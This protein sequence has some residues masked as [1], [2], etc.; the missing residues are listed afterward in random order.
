[1]ASEIFNTDIWLQA[2]AHLSF[3]RNAEILRLSRH[4]GRRILHTIGCG[5]EDADTTARR[6][7]LGQGSILASSKKPP[8]TPRR[9][10]IAVHQSWN[11]L[12]NH[13]PG[14]GLTD[15]WENG[16]HRLRHDENG[17]WLHVA[18]SGSH[19][20]ESS[21]HEETTSRKMRKNRLILTPT[22]VA[23][24][25]NRINNIRNTCRLGTKPECPL[26]SAEGFRKRKRTSAR[27]SI[28]ERLDLSH[29][30]SAVCGRK[31][32]FPEMW[33]SRISRVVRALRHFGVSC[34]N[35]ESYGRSPRYGHKH[36]MS[37]KRG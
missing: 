17:R 37:G 21:Q 7:G 3:Q 23:V 30:K 18:D 12:W 36:I 5:G 29:E 6:P 14:A 1:M 28:S 25:R 11:L 20:T 34:T 33:K 4:D 32:A 27:L 16:A 26:E 35:S 9:A 10:R 8:N 15:R 24:D 19:R 22:M 31:C 2:P 13:A